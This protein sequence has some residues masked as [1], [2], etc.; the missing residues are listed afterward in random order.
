MRYNTYPMSVDQF[1]KTF[2]KREVVKDKAQ[3]SQ[4]VTATCQH[5]AEI[6]QAYVLST[7]S[8]VGR[9]VKYDGSF[10]YAIPQVTTNAQPL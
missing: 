3:Y 10:V 2:Y 8:S 6:G 9:A 4:A 7:N 1:V 5:L